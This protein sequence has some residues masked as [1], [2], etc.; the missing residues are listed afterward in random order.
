M[1][2]MS[3]RLSLVCTAVALGASMSIVSN[4]SA[5]T[6]VPPDSLRGQ[7]LALGARSQA[8][9]G[10][11]LPQNDSQVAALA[12]LLSLEV[13]TAPVGTSTGGFVFTF[14]S[15]IG[16]LTRAAKSFGP[17]FAKRSL[18]TGKGKF[19]TEFNWLHANYDSVGGLD[20]RNGDLLTAKNQKNLPGLPAA[21]A[22]RLDLSS[23]TVVGFATYGLTNDLDIGIVV[24][25]T[26]VTVGADV[27]Y[28]SASNVDITPGGGLLI[29]PRT[30]AS[31]V[32]D[33]AVF[34][35]YHVWHQ[36]EG[37]LAVEIECRL[38]TGDT[39]AL[40]G[41]GVTRT[42]TGAIWSRGGKVSPHANIG[43]GFWSAAGPISGTGDVFAKHQG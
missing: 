27:R 29:V 21:A 19:S 26:R 39:N 15:Q 1:S 4:A 13:S 7:L 40:R 20:L 8:V 2:N 18:T 41:T 9:T 11:S 37:G 25:W 5:Q 33:I 34:G 17:T 30:S 24:P 42:T 43:Y 32:G 31:G 14:D 23:N 6:A 16:T 35:R 36:A 22:L 10:L 12:E 3:N 28:L 38:P